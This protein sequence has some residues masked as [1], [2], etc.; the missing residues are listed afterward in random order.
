MKVPKIVIAGTNSG[1]GK[2]T[3]T[4]G[5]MAALVKKGLKV[6]PYKVGPDYIDPMFHTFV[7]GR[8][9]RNLDSW[10]LEESVV[11][12]LFTKSAKDVDI[13][14]IEGVMGFYDGLGGNSLTGST[15][16]VSKIVKAP[17]ILVVNG[18]GASLSLAA[19]VKGF[20]EFDPGV[21]IRG[22]ILNNIKT[23]SHFELLKE[24]IEENTG[25]TV[26]GCL[27]KAEGYS[28][29]S[30]HLGLV[31]SE[32]IFDLRNKIEYLAEQV[33]KTID[34]ELL[35]KIAAESN[36]CKDELKD[37]LTGKPGCI[38]FPHGKRP[39]IAVARDKAFNFYYHDNLE[40]L[41]E[42]GAELKYFSPLEDT[43]LPEDI[44]GIYIGGGYPEVWAGELEE[45]KG[46]KAALKEVVNSGIPA[47]AECGGYMYMM[48]RVTD[49]EGNTFEM[50]GIIPG[51]STMTSKLQRFGYVEVEVKGGCVLSDMPA[52]V[53]AHEF[54]YSVTALDEKPD[55]CYKV[56][57]N[58]RNKEPLSWECGVKVNNLLAGYPH[59]HFWANTLLAKEFVSKC[60]EYGAARICR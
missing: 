43:C 56:I 26:I 50:T 1:C 55:S 25:I 39:R 7:T 14:V 18:E 52:K 48:D 11:T 31:P 24:T 28:F 60:A 30:R 9:S 15:A 34:L 58:R 47:Y 33:S 44:D 23:D 42:L 12:H 20:R 53:R 59:I 49:K 19:M 8:Y 54:H 32:E 2:T 13:S 17:V 40:L 45:N 6:Q 29:S 22:V 37:E 46:M 36:Y 38:K 10:M 57:K 4:A 16:H 27:P 3:V 51:R 21:D 5:I 41:E 35:V